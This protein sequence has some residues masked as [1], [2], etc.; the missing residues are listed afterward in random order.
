MKK[1][2]LLSAIFLFF[3][4]SLFAQK[5]DKIHFG[6]Y[7]GGNYARFSNTPNINSFQIQKGVFGV[8]A[9]GVGQYNINSNWSTNCRIG[10]EVKGSRWKS[11]AFNSASKTY[12]ISAMPQIRYGFKSIFVETGP[13]ISYFLFARSFEATKGW[14]FIKSKGFVPRFDF[15]L[16][17]GIGF[18]LD[19]DSNI[20]LRVSK[21]F[22]N[23][24]DLTSTDE[25]GN[26]IM[27]GSFYK[28]LVFQLSYQQFVF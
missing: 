4:A 22:C 16:H 25:M 9:G 28:S 18:W 14:E 13:E 10:M 2:I 17:S 12:Y 23:L 21:S 5:G 26:S 8:H 3:S 27:L 7:L 11:K 1:N 15:A 20:S 6:Y 24:A 19:M